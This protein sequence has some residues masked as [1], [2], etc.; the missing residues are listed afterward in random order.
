[1]TTLNL[2]YI[3]PKSI[4]DKQIVINFSAI[5]DR[6]SDPYI[7][8]NISIYFLMDTYNFANELVD[9]N[10]EIIGWEYRS[11]DKILIINFDEENCA[12]Y[13]L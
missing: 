11:G 3:T 9:D 2:R 5:E 4:N 8:K 13:Y 1:M 12:N 10:L 7:M 6:I